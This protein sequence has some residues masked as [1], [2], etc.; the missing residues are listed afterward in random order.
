[1]SKR[2]I[3]V[4]AAALAAAMTLATSAQAGR[5]LRIGMGLHFGGGHHHHHR[6]HF[7]RHRFIHLPPTTTTQ[8]V[9]V[10]KRYKAPSGPAQVAAVVKYAD[11]KGRIYDLASKVWFDGKS[12]CWSGKHAW[13][14]KG[15]AWFY[16]GK[17]WYET[18]G[19]WTLQQ[20]VAPGEEPAAVDCGTVPAF[21]AKLE[22]A[23]DKQATAPKARAD[24]GKAGAKAPVRTA[25]KGAGDKA[26]QPEAAAQCTKYLPSVGSSVTVPCE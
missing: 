5:G 14:F 10:V 11:G 9:T 22:P 16:G 8:D 18:D 20:A 23:G 15:G 13:T 17:R 21:A 24:G 6:P 7:H 1:M 3:A 19:M 25:E 26:D 4:A 2:T 12:S